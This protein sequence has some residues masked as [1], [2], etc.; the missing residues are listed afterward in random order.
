VPLFD[1]VLL[2]FSKTAGPV[3]DTSTEPPVVMVILP[4]VLL[5]AAAVET[6]DV[7]LLLMVRSSASV[8]VLNNTQAAPDATIRMFTKGLPPTYR[9]HLERGGVKNAN[10]FRYRSTFDACGKTG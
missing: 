3:F 8:E 7:V 10:P 2:E 9:G 6:G 5:A 4:G 1:T